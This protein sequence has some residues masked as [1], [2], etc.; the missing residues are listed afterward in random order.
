[1]LNFII[2]NQGISISKHCKNTIQQNKFYLSCMSHTERAPNSFQTRHLFT[3]LVLTWI[4]LFLFSVAGMRLHFEFVIKPGLVTQGCFCCCRPVLIQHHEIFFCST[5]PTSE[6]AG[7]AQVVLRGHG[8][9]N[10]P[11]L[12]KRTLRSLWHHTQRIKLG[13]ERN[14]E[15]CSEWSHVSFRGDEALLS[16]GKLNNRLLMGA[17]ERNSSFALHAWAAFAFHIELMLLQ[18]M[19]FLT[20][21]LLG[22]SPIPPWERESVAKWGLVAEWG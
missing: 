7:N 18:P 12:T 5:H 2:R 6:E 1:M 15:G 3:E 16:W 20:F 9:E 19:S 17:V 10:W 14:R 11:Q 21:S 8:Q 22:L 4:E 13:E